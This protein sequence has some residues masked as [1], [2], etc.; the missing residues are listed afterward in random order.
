MAGADSL[1]V[2]GEWIVAVGRGLE[3]PAGAR[4]RNLDGAFVMPGFNDSH[5]H[6]ARGAAQ[7][8]ENLRTMD[9]TG[10]LG[11]DFPVEP[12]APRR[13][14]YAAVTREGEERLTMEV[15]AKLSH[16]HTSP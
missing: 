15:L 13:V 3:A 9:L 2:S 11:T 12:M 16:F 8:G 10:V 7:W 5:I 14:L 4:V 1:L 6:F